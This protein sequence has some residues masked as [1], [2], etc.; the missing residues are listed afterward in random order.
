MKVLPTIV[1]TALFSSTGT[2]ADFLKGEISPDLALAIKAAMLSADKSDTSP[3]YF[4]LASK[5]RIKVGVGSTL[6]PRYSANLSK[7]SLFS[8]LSTV[9]KTTSTLFSA[10]ALK[11][12]EVSSSAGLVKRMRESLFSL[13][14]ALTAFYPNRM[15]SVL[16]NTTNAIKTMA[17]TFIRILF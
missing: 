2:G 9:V 13:K 16:E 6:S 17:S 14:I 11:R 10:A 4:F 15:Y 1:L 7:W 3:T 8:S 12:L 5:K